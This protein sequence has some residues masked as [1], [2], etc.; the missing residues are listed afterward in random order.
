M[1]DYAL[2]YNSV[3]GDRKYDADDFTTW[4]KPFFLTGVFNGDLQ[5]LPSE[6]M[7]V[8][9]ARGFVN[10][11]GKIKNFDE[12]T[13]LTL[14]RAHATLNRID[15]IIVRRND[16]DRDITILIQKGTNSETPVA[17]T[18][19]RENGIYDLVLAQVTVNAAATSITQEDVV[20]T[21]MDSELCGWVATT[22]DEIDFEQITLQFNAWYERIK[23]EFAEDV[24]GSLQTQID[25]LTALLATKANN[26]DVVKLVATQTFDINNVTFKLTDSNNNDVT[27]KLEIVE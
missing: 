20:D 6:N 27:F 2:F 11:E 16:S 9:V 17:P 1:A 22:V 24:P 19:I 15:N 3:D 18:P 12:I 25:N 7:N 10:V 23:A 14:D 8:T 4:L 26:S 5:V 21:R 13:T